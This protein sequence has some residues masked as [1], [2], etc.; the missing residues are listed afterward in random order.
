MSVG[1]QI[2]SQLHQ[3]SIQKN[4][5]L[6][7]NNHDRIPFFI[8]VT[9]SVM[10]WCKGAPVAVA[11][12]LACLTDMR[13]VSYWIQHPR[14]TSAETCMWWSD[15]LSCWPPRG[16]QVSHQMWILGNAYHIH[17]CQVRIRLPTLALKSRGDITRTPKQGY[18]WPHKKNLC[19][20]KIVLKRCTNFN[21]LVNSSLILTSHFSL[22]PPKK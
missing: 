17:F 15:R 18:Q 10:M 7:H 11:E 16:W 13:E 2:F 8:K 14:S 22:P 4:T 9:W 6:Q 20:P 19:P 12:W 3:K 5:G 1:V 21:P